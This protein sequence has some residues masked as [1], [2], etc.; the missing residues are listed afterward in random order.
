MKLPVGKVYYNL[1]NLNTTQ[2]NQDMLEKPKFQCR[3][4]NREYPDILGAIN[5]LCVREKVKWNSPGTGRGEKGLNKLR[6]RFTYKDIL[7]HR[8]I[9]RTSKL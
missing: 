2:E 1:H 8:E 4:C 6:T 9:I 5:C 3:Y 7:E